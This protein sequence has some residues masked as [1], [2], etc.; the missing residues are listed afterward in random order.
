M[1]ALALCAGSGPVRAFE[2]QTKSA[3]KPPEPARTQVPDKSSRLVQRQRVVSCAVPDL[4]GLS[5]AAAG[6]TLVKASLTLGGVDR[7]ADPRPAG[8]VIDQSAKPGSRVPC[9]SPIDVASAFVD[10]TPRPDCTVPKLIGN[11]ERSAGKEVIDAKLVVGGIDRRPQPRYRPGTVSDQ[12]PPPGTRVRCGSSVDFRVATSDDVGPPLC[13]VPDLLREDVNSARKALDRQK[14]TVGNIDTRGDNRP[15]G[16]IIDQSP[17]R[18]AL[19]PCGSPVNVVVA[20]RVTRV[21]RVPDLRG[22]DSAAAS[23][24]LTRVGL[25]LADAGE[26]E[27]NEK[28]GTVIEQNPSPGAPAEP[29]SAVRVWVAIPIPVVVPV[30]QPV[31]APLLIGRD[32]KLAIELIARSGLRVGKVT[33]RESDQPT[34]TIVGQ[35]YPPQTLVKCDAAIDLVVAERVTRVIRVPD[36]RG[37]DRA[38]A[39][40]ALTRV[41]LRLADAGERESNEKAGTV[42]EQNPSPGAPAEPD[43]AVRVWV[44][45]PIPVVVPDLVG[46]RALDADSTLLGSRLRTGVVRARESTEASGLVLQQSPAAGTRVSPGTPVDLWVAS[47]PRPVIVPQ[48]IGQL[49]ADAL[50][51]LRNARLLSGRTSE[52]E[53]KQAT[54]TVVEQRPAAGT[55]VQP[56]TAVDIALAIPV[57]VTSTAV[58]DL[59]GQRHENAEALL[60]RQTLR[61]GAVMSR[62]SSASAGVIVDQRPAAGQQVAPG[63]PVDIWIA[64]PLP[65][66]KVTVPDL[67]GRTQNVATA[68]IQDLELL[69]GPVSERESAEPRGTVVAQDPPAGTVVDAGARISMWLAVPVVPGPTPQTLITVPRL[70]DYPLEQAFVVLRGAGLQPG[71]VAQPPSSSRAGIVTFQFPAAGAQVPPG[72]PIDLVVAAAASPLVPLIQWLGVAALIGFGIVAAAWSA[73]SQWRRLFSIPELAPHMD[74]GI[75]ASFPDDGSLT[76]FEV[77][78]EA[79]TD[80]GAQT[81]DETNGF[82]A[83]ELAGNQVL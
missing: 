41:G 64:T 29:D 20:E 21:I 54:G 42:I 48:L 43:S 11:D 71:A 57:R 45:I 69:V 6:R 10:D 70:I 74:A 55:E 76:D 61:I 66:V 65:P 8:T 50:D 34:G 67:L 22:R 77:T 72:T 1:A 52:R 15:K 12:S 36:L 83:G 73:R 59:V 14:L 78:L 62:E 60:A 39:S 37:R 24:A 81:L 30:C 44:A 68:A 51:L 32:E 2:P 58:P 27:S 28:A 49:R 31:R 5:V 38:A 16:S 53:S 9:G 46:R 40:D 25:R 33:R 63:S 7:R 35:S 13:R 56:G 4:F 23:D 17:G 80:R 18:G 3:P 82:I 79:R 19:V 47:T 26:R 75:Q